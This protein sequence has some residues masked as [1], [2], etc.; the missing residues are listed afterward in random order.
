MS[1]SATLISP[2]T[3]AKYSAQ[4]KWSLFSPIFLSRYSDVADAGRVN[5][6]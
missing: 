1:I 5:Q 3:T 6:P 4:S 2:K